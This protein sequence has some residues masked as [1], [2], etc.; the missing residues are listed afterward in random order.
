MPTAVAEIVAAPR[1]ARRSATPTKRLLPGTRWTQT[2]AAVA[3]GGLLALLLWSSAA[4]GL[5]PRSSTPDRT[6][7]APVPLRKNL[8][9]AAQL[10][11]AKLELPNAC[12]EDHLARSL[13]AQHNF[14]CCT[15]C[16]VA[17]AKQEIPLTAIAVVA[18]TCRVCH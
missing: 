13:T 18:D 10:Q 2:L 16:H 8:D 11:L 14:Q 12:L 4:T 7:G 15:R 6:A 5:P 1:V 17:G 9:R 3:V